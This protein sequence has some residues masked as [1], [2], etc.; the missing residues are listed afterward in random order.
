M[1]KLD[2][3]ILDLLQKNARMTIK[4]IAQQVNLTSPAVSE[5]IRRMEKQEIIL[6]YTVKLNTNINK[7]NVNA[8][9]SITVPVAERALFKEIIKPQRDILKC[10]HV[11]GGQSFILRVRCEDMFS[12]EELLGQLQ[13]A[14][15][16]STQI[17]LSDIT[18]AG[19]S[20]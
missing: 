16:T 7:N 19:V 11:T 17:I 5:R 18:V 6:G 15:Q 13:K 8:L 1:D 12:L 3:D 10:Y 9:I 14:G 4:E 20:Y 2:Q